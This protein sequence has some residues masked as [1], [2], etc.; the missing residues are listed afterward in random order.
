[1]NENVPVRQCVACIYPCMECIAEEDFCLS[2]NSGYEWVGG[3][4]LNKNVNYYFNITFLTD[5]TTFF[6]NYGPLNLQLVN[7][8]IP[9]N[10]LGVGL[11]F[12][13]GVNISADNSSVNYQGIISS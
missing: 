12:P 2:C 13:Q 9:N 7:A 11:L 4:C 3:R 6:T 8:T 10:T 5:S 1:M